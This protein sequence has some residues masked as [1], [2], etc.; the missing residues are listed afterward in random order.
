[1]RSHQAPRRRNG[2]FGRPILTITIVLAAVAGMAIGGVALANRDNVANAPQ[3]RQ[4]SGSAAAVAPGDVETT[5]EATDADT[6]SDTTASSSAITMS[7]TGDIIMGSAPSKLPAQ[8]GAGFFDSVTKGLQSDLVMGNLEQPLTTDTGSSKCG[9]GSDNCYAF[10]APPSYAEHLADAG[11]QLLNTAN[12]HS[13]D[14]GSAG[15]RNTV[16]ALE[17]AGLQH[18]GARDEITVAD[19]NGLKVAVLGFSPYSSANNLNDLDAARKIVSRAAD[20]ADLVVVQVHMGAEGADKSHVKPGSEIFFGENRGDPI[21]FAHAVVDAGADVV[22]GHGPHVLRGMQ[23]YKGKLIAYSLGNFAGGGRTLSRSGVLK[24]GGIL[25]VSLTA[26]GS[27]AGG[28]FLSTFMDS[29]GKPIR[30]K[31]NER[32]RKLVAELSA[33]DF[34]DTAAKIGD[35]GSLSPPA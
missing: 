2:L 25:H 1:M 5:A 12:N 11:Y 10:R 23:F 4:P 32:G 17:D 34:G 21:A 24:Y 15:Y 22:I 27:W 29:S 9:A 35:D 28:K 7:A 20:R 18:T 31:E 3:W 19:I 16:Q 13:S 6:K 30:D 14:F 8:D 26:D 33:D